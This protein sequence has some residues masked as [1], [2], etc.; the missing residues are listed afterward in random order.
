MSVTPLVF[1][2]RNDPHHGED[3]A[4]IKVVLV[5]HETR[6]CSPESAPE[7]DVRERPHERERERRRKERNARVSGEGGRGI[8]EAATGWQY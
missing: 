8:P 4:D 3:N 1:A 5:C 7:R 6:A 2:H